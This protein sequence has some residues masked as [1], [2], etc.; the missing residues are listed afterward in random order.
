MRI[1]KLN[2]CKEF[3]ENK[4]LFLCVFIF[5]RLG[6]GSCEFRGGFFKENSEYRVCEK[7]YELIY[8]CLLFIGVIFCIYFIFINLKINCV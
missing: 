1:I 8:V 5:L 6:V 2:K 3:F 4:I 7:K